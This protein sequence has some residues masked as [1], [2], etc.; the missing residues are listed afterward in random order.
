MAKKVAESK[1]L[2]LA[3][4]MFWQLAGDLPI[5]N[6]KSLLRAMSREFKK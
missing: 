3:G 1:R 2:N 4:V 6:E 5:D